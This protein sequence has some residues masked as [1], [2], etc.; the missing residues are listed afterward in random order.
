MCTAVGS[1]IYYKWSCVCVCV[2]WCRNDCQVLVH[3]DMAA[4]MADG[5]KFYVSSNDVILSEGLDGINS[6]QCNMMSDSQ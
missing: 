6:M 5:I 2:L 1:I 4:A 3:V